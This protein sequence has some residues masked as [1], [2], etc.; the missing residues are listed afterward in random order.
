MPGGGS[1]EGIVMRTVK[2]SLAS[3]AIVVIAASGCS[4]SGDGGS[5]AQGESGESTGAAAEA[6]EITEQ[7]KQEPTTI[8]VTEPLKSA[9]A[10]GETIVYMKCAL[11]ECQDSSDYLQE[12]VEAVGWTYEE[13]SF[14]QAVP[15]TLVT[16]MRQ[17]LDD[18]D[19]HA[20]VVGGTPQ[21]V[22]QSVVPEYEA[23][24]VKIVG[25]F[26]GPM[27]YDDTVI[28][29]SAAGLN[30]QWSEMLANWVIADSGG[31]AQV[32]LQTVND[33]PVCKEGHDSFI[34]TI[35]ENCPECSVT[36]LNNTIAQLAG[37]EIVDTVVAGL[38]R[39]PDIDYV[40]TTTSS[41]ITGLPSALAAAGM[42]DRVK[43]ASGG[44]TPGTLSNIQAGTE[45]ATTGYAVA[46]SMWTTLDIVLRDMQDMD[47]D[48]DGNGGMPTQLLTEDVDFEVTYNYD[49]PADWRDQFKQLWQVG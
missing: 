13:V 16:G 11:V 47:F 25:N 4:S 19:P 30:T 15:A 31:D 34:A 20:V 43:V 33:F 28:G 36:V 44:G 40:V 6:A 7:N 27:E 12:A 23:A 49:K 26:V 22:W 8:P 14:D 46:Y 5:S 45:D 9:P 1:L 48:P 21:A 24:G 41:F 10:P 3:L 2:G 29:Q 17:A 35:E 32:L 42:T 37:G 39:E 18:Y 38:Q